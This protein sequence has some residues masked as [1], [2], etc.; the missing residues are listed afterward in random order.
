MTSKNKPKARWKL[1]DVYELG[2]EY[3]CTNCKTKVDTTNKGKYLPLECPYCGA[4][5]NLEVNNEN[6]EYCSGNSTNK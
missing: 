6:F 2:Y 4:R 3:E 5:M 1:V